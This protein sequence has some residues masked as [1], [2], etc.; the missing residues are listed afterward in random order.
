MKIT[1]KI[2]LKNDEFIELCK[3]H[4]VRYLY[5]FGS[6]VTHN[7]DELQSDIDLVV[8]IN[9]TDPIER[10][11]QLIQLWDKLE[12]F[13]NRKVDLLTPSSIKNPILKKS[14]DNTKILIYDGT[15]QEIFS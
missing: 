6:A 9:S 11:E 5:A 7:F 13:F 2:N 10:G 4:K 12:L 1:E 8:E 3:L 15:G 14:I